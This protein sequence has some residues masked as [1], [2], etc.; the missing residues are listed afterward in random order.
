MITYPKSELCVLKLVLDRESFSPWVYFWQVVMINTCWNV[1]ICTHIYI[2]THIS[3]S[4][5]FNPRLYFEFHI[6]NTKVIIYRKVQSCVKNHLPALFLRILQIKQVL[7][8]RT[9]EI[10]AMVT[11]T[12]VGVF[13]LCLYTSSWGLELIS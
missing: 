11:A 10:V 2:C 3:L 7:S 9:P 1:D 8:K 4:G 12:I 13:F 5:S 6:Y